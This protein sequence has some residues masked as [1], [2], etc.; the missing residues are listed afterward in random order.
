[1]AFDQRLLNIISPKWWL[2]LGLSFVFALPELIALYAQFDLHPEKIMFGHNHVSGIRWF[3]IDSQFGRF[4]GTGPIM[5]TNPPPLHQLFF[6]HTFLWSFLPWS[7]LYPVAIY[8]S[9][10]YFKKQTLADKKATILLLGYFC[11]DYVCEIAL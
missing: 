3:F 1:V 4:F 9:V 11:S 10:R 5:T 7:L 8:Y 2:A 6:I